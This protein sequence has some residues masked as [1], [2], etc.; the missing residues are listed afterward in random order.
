MEVLG[1]RAMNEENQEATVAKVSLLQNIRAA[2]W[3]IS[4]MCPQC[5][6]ALWTF[7]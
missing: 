4:T 3:E 7:F 1:D 6:D 2:S 5:I